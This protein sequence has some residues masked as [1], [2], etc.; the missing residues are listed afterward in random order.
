[1][2]AILLHGTF[3]F[4]LFLLG[5]IETAFAPNSMPLVVCSFVFP[6]CITIGGLVYAVRAYKEV[7][8]MYDG[9]WRPVR[10]EGDEEQPSAVSPM[11]GVVVS[12]QP[13]QQPNIVRGVIVSPPPP[14]AAL[15]PLPPTTL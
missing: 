2:P 10:V 11:H 14:S 5:A 12:D 9:N 7:E 15:R 6:I 1:M 8:N 3:D 13:A 4:V